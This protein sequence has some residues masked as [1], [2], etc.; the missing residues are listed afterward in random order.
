MEKRILVVDDD[1]RSRKLIVMILKN[2]GYDTAEAGELQEA[3]RKLYNAKE[4]SESFSLVI[5]DYRLT[6]D[7]DPRKS[8]EALVNTVKCSYQIPVLMI[9][10]DS[11]VGTRT[12]ADKFL[13]KPF[14]FNE[15]LSAVKELLNL[16]ET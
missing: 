3:R 16:S 1:S 12:G 15:L 11:R 4:N 8:G 13:S 14:T 5:T 7:G 10:L 6:E 9:S 2:E